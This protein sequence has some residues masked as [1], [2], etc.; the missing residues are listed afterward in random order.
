MNYIIKNDY[1]IIQGDKILDDKL[2]D[3]I[4]KFTKLKT[5]V[6]YDLPLNTLPTNIIEIEFDVYYN[7][8]I[9]NL[10]YS[11]KKIEF[12]YFS[13]F[14]QT[15]DFLPADLEYLA[16]HGCFNQP[17]D[18]LPNNL[19]YLILGYCFDQSIDNLPDSLNYLYVGLIFSKKINKLP[20]NL[21]VLGLNCKYKY[22][23]D[24]KL[25]CDKLNIKLE[26][27]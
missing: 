16:L 9:D 8:K 22:L 1:I 15:I 25:F 11:I 27:Y 18:N 24:V 14:N 5:S 26:I 23:D 19:K 10:P 2:I 20:Q 3:I 21:I 6:A 17:I 13:V 12:S 4:K 7:Q